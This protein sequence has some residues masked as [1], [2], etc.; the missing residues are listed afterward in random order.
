M[1]RIVLWIVAGSVCL[2]LIGP[3]AIVIPLSF[4]KSEFLAFPPPGYT[5]RWYEQFFSDPTWTDAL[6]RSLKVSAIATLL[7]TSVGTGS[8]YALSARTRWLRKVSEPLL[9]MPMIVP[10]IVFA[11]GAY[12]AAVH[13]GL[14]GSLWLL[15]AAHSVLALPFVVLTVSAA[16]STLDA[17]LENAA[18]SLGARPYIAFFLV[19]LPLIAPSVLGSAIMAAVLSFDEAV[20]ALFLSPDLAPTLPVRMYAS[21]KLELDPVL[22]VAA[23]VVSAATISLGLVIMLARGWL[24]RRDRANSRRPASYEGERLLP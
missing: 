14:F 18:R 16:L 8:A 23:T 9:I 10:V 2:F 5:T 6:F 21:I 3:I 4:S 17:D 22:P 11:I 7:A 20:V 1:A 13:L 12:L 15:G 19:T 24:F